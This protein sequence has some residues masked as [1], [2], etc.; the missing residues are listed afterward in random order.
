MSAALVFQSWP[1]ANGCGLLVLIFTR[2]LD[3]GM[4]DSVQCVCLAQPPEHPLW[5]R[6]IPGM[7]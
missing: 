6:V 3:G 7:G 2:Q 5:L 4:P 1:L